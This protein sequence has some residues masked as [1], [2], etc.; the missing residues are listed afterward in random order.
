MG[1]TPKQVWAETM[2]DRIVD[3]IDR[4]SRAHAMHDEGAVF[5]LD[6]RTHVKPD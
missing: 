2:A 4:L 5:A 3:R 1:D 6:V